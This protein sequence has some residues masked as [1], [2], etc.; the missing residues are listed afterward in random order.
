MDQDRSALEIISFYVEDYAVHRVQEGLAA[1]DDEID[2]C[3]GRS[4]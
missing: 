2:A 1:L 3:T 4:D